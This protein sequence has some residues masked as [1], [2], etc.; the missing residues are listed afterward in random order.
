M[1]RNGHRPD[2]VQSAELSEVQ[3]T[4][5]LEAHPDFLKRY[6]DLLSVLEV[7]QREFA[8]ADPA[9]GELVDL[10][11]AMLVR[12][13]G[14]LARQHEQSSDLI[15]ASR[16]NLQSQNRIHAAV[17]ALL[18]ARSLDHL[19]EILTIDLVGLLH[20]DAAALCLEGSTVAPANNQGVRVVPVGTIE[21]IFDTTRAVALRDNIEGDRRLYGEAAGLVQSE[22]L[23]RL[24][25]RDG[26][27]IALLALGCRDPSRFHDGQ[28]S[29]LLIFLAA[30]MEHCIRTWLDLPR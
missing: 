22:A 29:E 9:G 19:I 3:V 18:K 14:E 2:A 17:V 21:R 11:D 4:S 10:Q 1:S 8:D 27:P 7:P 23:L 25:V 13:R 12:M 5:F 28:G 26:A 16:S 20:V 6:P 15:D 24:T 30:I